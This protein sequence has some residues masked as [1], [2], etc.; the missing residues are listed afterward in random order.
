MTVIL[1]FFISFQ[2]KVICSEMAI[3]VLSQKM[4]LMETVRVCHGAVGRTERKIIKSTQTEQERKHQSRSDG[5]S[6]NTFHTHTLTH[7]QIHI[8]HWWLTLYGGARGLGCYI[9]SPTHQLLSQRWWLN[10]PMAWQV[11]GRQPMASLHWLLRRSLLRR[12]VGVYVDEA[13]IM[14]LVCKL[15]E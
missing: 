14:L 10:H 4:K 8:C 5:V 15:I 13:L 7:T 1:I 6:T 3:V 2:F 12:L 9:G 11:P